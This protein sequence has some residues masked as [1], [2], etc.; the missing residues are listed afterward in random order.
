[1]VE[2]LQT[3]DDDA[4]EQRMTMHSTHAG[5]RSGVHAIGI[6]RVPRIGRCGPTLHVHGAHIHGRFL[7]G[8]HAIHLA[9][10]HALHLAVIHTFH[11]AGVHALHLAVIHTF[12]LAGIVA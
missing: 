9:V 12:H 5:H 8:I 11:L 6:V 3:V 2:L 10:V 1:A 7:A 4:S